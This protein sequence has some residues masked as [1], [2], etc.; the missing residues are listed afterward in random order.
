MALATGDLDG[1]PGFARSA[2]CQGSCSGCRS[3]S[4]RACPICRAIPALTFGIVVRC[5][6]DTFGSSV[7]KGMRTS[8][9]GLTRCLASRM[10]ARR[11]VKRSASETLRLPTLVRSLTSGVLEAV[12]VS[13]LTIS[14]V[15]DVGLEL[16]ALIRRIASR[17]VPWPMEACV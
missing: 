14:R 15:A 4:S 2:S 17:A 10:R 5:G 12:M 3:V 11:A 6:L 9:D 1:C 8:Q 16:S 13:E 7:I